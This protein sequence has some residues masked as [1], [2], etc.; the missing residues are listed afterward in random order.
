LPGTDFGER[1]VN[2]GVLVHAER[3]FFRRETMTVHPRF[4]LELD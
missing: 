3:F 4:F 2:Q 1:S